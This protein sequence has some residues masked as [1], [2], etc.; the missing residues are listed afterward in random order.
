MKRYL[1]IVGILA[2]IVAIVAS[3]LPK[4]N[5]NAADVVNLRIFVGVGTGTHPNDMAVENKLADQ[6]NAA[7]PDIQIKFDYN[8]NSTARSILLTQVA[9]DNAPDIVGPIGI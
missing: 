7:H 8:D 6:W 9:G 2:V 5:A 3:A 1:R 4:Q